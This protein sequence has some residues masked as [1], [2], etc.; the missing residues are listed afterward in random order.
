MIVNETAGSRPRQFLADLTLA[1][2]ATAETARHETIEACRS[3][4]K[5]YTEQLHSLVDGESATLRQA[6]E[7]DIAVVREWSKAEIERTRFE[8]E[9]RIAARHGQLDEAL[10]E[11]SAAIEVERQRV[12]EQIQAYQVELSRFFDRLMSQDTDPA[13]F[14]T[15]AAEM[16]ASPVFTDPDPGMIV[17]DFRLSSLQ[18]APARFDAGPEPEPEKLPDRWWMESPGSIAARLRSIAGTNQP[19]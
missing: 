5:A 7:A 14:A 17:H 1:M 12:Y 11:Y 19:G 10:Q 13:S 2:S 4:A 3:D 15:M 6:A 8:A 9:E 18:P 16:P